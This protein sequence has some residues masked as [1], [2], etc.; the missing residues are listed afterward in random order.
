MEWGEHDDMLPQD[1]LSLVFLI[2]IFKL[3]EDM[4]AIAQF[5]TGRSIRADWS[6]SLQ[7]RKATFIIVSQESSQEN[8]AL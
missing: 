5:S 7:P 4:N 3:E 6:C 8:R 2:L 1:P